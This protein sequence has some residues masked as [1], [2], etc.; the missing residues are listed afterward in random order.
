[1][2]VNTDERRHVEL[3]AAT[4]AAGLSA[5]GDS[6]AHLDPE[7]MARVAIR[8]A[9]KIHALVLELQAAKESNGA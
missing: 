7:R 3:M 6:D 1:V 8:Q 5:G 4:I 9:Q 2:V